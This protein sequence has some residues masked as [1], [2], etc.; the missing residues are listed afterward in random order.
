M[1]TRDRSTSILVAKIDRWLPSSKTCSGCDHAFGEGE[2]TIA[3]RQWQC[4]SCNRVL[5][6]DYNASINILKKGV[7]LLAINYRNPRCEGV[8]RGNLH[9]LCC[10]AAQPTRSV[11]SLGTPHF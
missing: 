5:D 10:S 1:S 4:S 6:R 9:N 11:H 2:F 3:M 7:T 8:S